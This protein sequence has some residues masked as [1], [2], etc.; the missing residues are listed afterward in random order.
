MQPTCNNK[1]EILIKTNIKI[2]NRM[3]GKLSIPKNKV[4]LVE[5]IYL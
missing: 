5:Q 1:I 2:S 3:G 4:S